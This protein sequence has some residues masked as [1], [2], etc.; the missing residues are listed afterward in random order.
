[1]KRFL[2]LISIYFFLSLSSFANHISGG[3]IYYT[4]IRQSGNAFL[5]HITIKLLRKCDSPEK[6]SSM[7]FI[8]ILNKKTFAPAWEDVVPLNRVITKSIIEP[9]ACITNPPEVCYEIGF[10]EINVL[11]P[12]S[13][14]GYNI[15]YQNCCSSGMSNISHTIGITLIAEIPGTNPVGTGPVNSSAR[16]NDI[17]T[18]MI[19]ANNFFTFDASATDA[20]GDQLVYS[21]CD[22]YITDP[23]LNGMGSDPENPNEI[24]PLL[25]YSTLEYK[26]PYKASAPMGAGVVINSR[27]GLITGVP[28]ARGNYLVTICVSEL[29]NGVVIATQRKNMQITAANCQIAQASLQL[30]YS[31]CKN[32]TVNFKNLSNSPLVTSYFWDFGITNS[33]NDTSSLATP[34]FTYP[35]TGI[36]TV[37]LIINRQLQCYDSATAIVK[38]YPGLQAGF[39]VKGTCLGATTQFQD[40]SHSIY[41][42]INYWSWDLDKKDRVGIIDNKTDTFSLP[43][44]AWQYSLGQKTIQLIVGN[45]KG[46][47]DTVTKVI[48]IAIN[49]K[50][51]LAFRDTLICTPDSIQMQASGIGNFTWLPSL[52]MIDPDKGNPTVYPNTTKIYTVELNDGSCK[53]TDSVKIR[54]V[55]HVT[56]LSLG[57]TTICRTDT[58]HLLTRSD[59]LHFT[60]TPSA[61]IDD[62]TLQSPFAIPS[63]LV[64]QYN[65]V[66][67][68]GSCLAYD[69]IIVN[70]VPYPQ[71]NAGRDTII[72]YN[73]PAQLQGTLNSSQFYW[74]PANALNNATILN[75]VAMPAKTTDFVLNSFENKGCPKPGRDTMR[76]IV[77]PKVYPFAGNDTSIVVGQPLQFHATGG[78][79]YQWT[80]STGLNNTT[81]A[82]PVGIYNTG[83]G[84]I[85]Y[86]LIVKDTNNCSAFTFIKVKVFETS[87]YVFVPGAF[88][89]D[90]DG[91][92]DVLRPVPVGVKNI[93]RFSVFNRWGQLVFTT[94]AIGKGW[95]GKINGRPQNSNVYVWLVDAIDYKG[96][97]ISLKGT[98]S[99]IR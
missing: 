29:R 58:I 78:T 37:K 24:I 97:S 31:N 41:G 65:V 27:T 79:Q 48:N 39:T 96:N 57:D 70:T 92:N 20:D 76:I 13:A 59:G 40:T 51:S 67:R 49:P 50:I 85:N 1:M 16:F 42:T 74:S 66:A 95:D 62:P 56:L 71:V 4:Y 5:Y 10:Y 12:P 91:L 15:I 11:I 3:E 45:D 14:D 72:C 60:W 23:P 99:L 35:D 53:S 81:I 32:F 69:Q 55:D 2:L 94:N 19:C 28:P 54:V 87:P 68:I 80:P 77:L 73:M 98:V 17:D 18:V 7:V 36:Y 44:P 26:K 25:Q 21:F 9:N 6:L 89:P 83:D 82:D 75:P 33:N 86:K 43:N 64:T 8:H 30:Q 38:I 84:I 93:K 47:I 22:A 63:A 88:T 90:N 34:S 52:N 46:C 61:T